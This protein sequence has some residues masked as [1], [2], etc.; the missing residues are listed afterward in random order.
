MSCTYMRFG[1]AKLTT[2]QTYGEI[3]KVKLRSPAHHWRQKVPS[4]VHHISLWLR[5]EFPFGSCPKA[6]LTVATPAPLGQT[7]FNISAL[8][9]NPFHSII[10]CMHAFAQTFPFQNSDSTN[11]GKAVGM[12]WLTYTHTHAPTHIYKWRIVNASWTWTKQQKQISSH[13]CH[14]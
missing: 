3:R 11:I 7:S 5:P 4:C 14:L 2:R 8:N 6:F 13:Q 12:E 10:M 9:K 1:Q